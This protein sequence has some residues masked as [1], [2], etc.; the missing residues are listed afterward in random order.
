MPPRSQLVVLSQTYYSTLLRANLQLSQTVLVVRF[1]QC[2]RGP[3]SAAQERHWKSAQM[4]SRH[5]LRLMSTV[6]AKLAAQLG[7]AV[8][9]V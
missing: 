1:E 5:S 6:A 4:A 9:T 3:P 2:V 7:E 8:P